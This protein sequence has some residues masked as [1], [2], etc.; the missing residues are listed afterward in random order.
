[1]PKGDKFKLKADPDDGTTPV[2]NLLLE[3]VAIAD[4]N[5]TEKGLILYLWRQTYGWIVEGKRLQETTLSQ[6]AL[7]AAFSVAPHTIYTALKSLTQKNIVIRKDLGQGK[8]YRYRMNTNIST[9]NSHSIDLEVL[10]KVSGVYAPIKGSQFSIP[11]ME[12]YTPAEDKSKTPSVDEAKKEGD[13]S[14]GLPP[15]KTSGVPPTKTYSPTLL[16]EILNKDN[17][18]IVPET[19]KINLTTWNDFLEMRKKMK[20]PPTQNAQKLLVME[21]VKL[22]ENGNEPNKVLEQSIMNNWKGVF[23][24]KPGPTGKGVYHGTNAAYKPQPPGTSTTPHG[25]DGDAEAPPNKD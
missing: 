6:D 15:T 22:Q 14:K 16:K 20:S 2:A 18:Y 13:I 25:I 4:L 17:K 11:S 19:L 23:A 7:G 21:L 5:G 1:M 8:G 9:W 24:L 10:K 12:T 3:A